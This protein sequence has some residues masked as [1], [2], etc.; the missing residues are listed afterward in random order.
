MRES[1]AMLE[2]RKI[3]D[4][5]SLRRINM[6][7]DE[8]NKELDKSVEWFAREMAKLSAERQVL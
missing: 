5:I 7:D 2:I 6:S 4:E 3:R 8:I 1:I